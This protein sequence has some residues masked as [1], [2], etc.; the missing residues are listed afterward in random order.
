ME[1]KNRMSVFDAAQ[2]L[3][4]SEKT[5]RNGLKDNSFPF[6]FAVKQSGRWTYIITVQKF[7]E[8]TGIKVS[9]GV[10]S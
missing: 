1:G 6:G 10:M 9:K 4:C 2:L 5:I 7:E 3:N 8:T